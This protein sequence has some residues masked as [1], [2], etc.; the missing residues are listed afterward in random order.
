MRDFGLGRKFVNV[1]TRSKGAANKF[2]A[3][4]HDAQRF[5][6]TIS[7]DTWQTLSKSVF[8]QKGEG[9]SRLLDDLQFIRKYCADNGVVI[10]K[11]VSQALNQVESKASVFAERMNKSVSKGIEPLKSCEYGTKFTEQNK[12]A[13]DVIKG[14]LNNESSAAFRKRLTAIKNN[15]DDAVQNALQQ[16]EDM[17]FDLRSK[18]SWIDS[19]SLF[20]TKIGDVAD[21][22]LQSGQKFYHG[23]TKARSIKKEGFSLLPKK[24][25]ANMSAR[26]L[27]EGIYLTPDKKVAAKFAG[28]CGNIM[29]LDVN[30]NR[31]AAVNDAQIQNVQR[32]IVSEFGN[33]LDAHQL[34]LLLKELFKRNGYNAAYTRQAL[35]NHGI[36]TGHMGKVNDILCG[37][38]QSQLVV[39]DPKDISIASKTISERLQNQLLQLET[40]VKVSFRFL[41][42][43][44]E[45]GLFGIC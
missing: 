12:E 33:V 28:E 41:K 36:L 26:E 15:A 31:V 9:A 42:A 4:R 23:T 1:F 21:D 35:G 43:R 40:A 5:I 25:Q 10:P 17:F 13:I 34:E 45:M 20:K 7:E 16:Q 22:V 37:G 14:F 39:F 30:L 24:K 8:Q 44:S 18:L 3:K 19:S 11:E 2:A 32:A 27:G 38:K 29:H 6:S